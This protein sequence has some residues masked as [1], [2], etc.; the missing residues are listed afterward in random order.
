MANLKDP[1][2]LPTIEFFRPYDHVG[3]EMQAITNAKDRIKIER[4][5]QVK[6][7]GFCQL[8][9]FMTVHWKGYTVDEKGRTKLVEDSRNFLHRPK[10]FQVGHY[11]VSKCWDIALQ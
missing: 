4:T 2:E 6:D 1:K 5:R 7:A 11:Q 9:D 3:Y 8:D 10:V